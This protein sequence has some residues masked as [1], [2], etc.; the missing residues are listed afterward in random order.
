MFSTLMDIINSITGSFRKDVAYKHLDHTMHSLQDEVLPAFDTIIKTKNLQAVKKNNLLTLTYKG[1]NI[2]ASDNYKALEKMRES[3]SYIAKQDKVIKNIIDRD[4]QDV[5]SSKSSTAKSAA[6]IKML[7][8]LASMNAFVLD[9]LYVVLTEEKSSFLP[10]IKFKRV[11]E[12][13]PAFQD[14]F[15]VYGFEFDK[16]LENLPRV[17]DEVL[18]TEGVADN[19][20]VDIML[21]KTGKM[22]KL[23]TT[24]FMGNPIYHIRMW[25]VDRDAKKYESLKVKKQLI[26]LKLMELKLEEE[27]SSDPHLSKQIKYYEEKLSDIEYSI[28][29]LEK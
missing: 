26:E 15:K 12:G 28:E 11:K 23:P 21:S 6:I 2:V 19:S 8:D 5:V 4:L 3:F 17:S 10:K 20:M 14:L 29:K 16:F 7:N 18:P 24:G 22:I 25:L 9:L 1:C 27:E 13:I